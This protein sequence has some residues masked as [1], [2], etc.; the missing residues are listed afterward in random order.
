[1]KFDR[2]Q[3][4]ADIADIIGCDYVGDPDYPVKGMN[5]IHVVDTGDIVFVDHPKY[6]DKALASKASVILINK[7]VECP[8][9]K[10]LLISERPFDDFNRLADH[11]YNLAPV[12][13]LK[14]E[15]AKIHPSAHI[16]PNVLIDKEVEI[17][18]NC[19]VQSNVVI[20]GR[21]S[22]GDNVI[23]QSGVVLGGNA[24]YY[25]KKTNG[26]DALRSTGSIIIEDNVE[27]GPNT[28]IDRGVS[29][30]TFIGK[31]TKIDNQVQIGHDTK[32]GKHCLIA[33]Q[34]GIAGCVIVEDEVTIW[35][36][37][38]I[39]SGL[40]IGEKAT[41]LACS[42]ISKSVESN[43]T[44]FGAPAGNFRTKYRELASLAKLPDI[45]KNL[46]K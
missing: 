41:L 14:S 37:V 7:K 40:T 20:R 45:I 4:L 5:E 3:E 21:V 32:I 19:W 23:L 46:K 25:K 30:Q 38:G 43:A 33:A 39:A 27:I 1:M 12:D 8:E 6:Y 36:Q 13:Q 34:A 35:G 9:G 42:G 28:T 26:Y 22:I 29:G 2:T 17:G 18:K 44:Y 31:G 24:F 11:F 16:E 15:K 10:A